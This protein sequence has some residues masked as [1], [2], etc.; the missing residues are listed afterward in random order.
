MT[1][2]EALRIV[3]AYRRLVFEALGDGAA[4]DNDGGDT[5]T[6]PPGAD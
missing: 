5:G 3:D 1:T 6:V 4:A 2:A